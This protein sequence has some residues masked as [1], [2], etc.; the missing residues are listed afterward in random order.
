[1]SVAARAIGQF[2]ADNDEKVT[3]NAKKQTQSFTARAKEFKHRGE[4]FIKQTRAYD[5]A[6]TRINDGTLVETVAKQMY[7]D[8]KTHELGM[9]NFAQFPAYS[10]IEQVEAELALKEHLDIL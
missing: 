3:N 8:L 6:A 4:A 9:A 10:R 1:M 2:A 7:K 5:E